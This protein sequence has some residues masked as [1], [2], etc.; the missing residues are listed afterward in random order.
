LIA[1]AN[2]RQR[3]QEASASTSL[4]SNH[5]RPLG[6]TPASSNSPTAPE[7]SGKPLRRDSRLGKYFEYDLSKMVNSKGGFLLEDGQ[8]IDDNVRRKEKERERQR[9]MKN[10]EPR[11]L[12]TLCSHIIC[13]L[14][15]HV[16]YS[17]VLGS[18]P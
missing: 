12:L 7:A 4:N 15:S 5:K 9:A 6:V 11:K 8:E 2:Q 3:E 13:W 1:K 14:G 18:S 17:Y 16:L 10:L